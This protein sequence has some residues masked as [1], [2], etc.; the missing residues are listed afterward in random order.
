MTAVETIRRAATLM[1]ARAKDATQGD[2]EVTDW[3][4]VRAG[5]QL[6]SGDDC[7]CGG[8]IGGDHDAVHIASWSPA[9][10]LAVADLLDNAAEDAELQGP[11]GALLQHWDIR[12]D[13]TTRFALVLALGYL[14]ENAD[15]GTDT[16]G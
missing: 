10:A 7:G 9:V 1:R 8:G 3:A 5:D 2:W 6:I 11:G 15:T 14:R 12:V 13:I 4:V 16:D